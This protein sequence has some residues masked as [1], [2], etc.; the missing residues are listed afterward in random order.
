MQYDG[1]LNE[2]SSPFPHHLFFVRFHLINDDT[3]YIYFLCNNAKLDMKNPQTNHNVLILQTKKRN[4]LQWCIL[5][6]PINI[7]NT[8][9]HSITGYHLTKKNL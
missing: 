4:K 2:N 5:I 3:N 9:L 6:V 1:L 7:T 8:I